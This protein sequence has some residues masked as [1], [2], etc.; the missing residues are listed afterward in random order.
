MTGTNAMAGGWHGVSGGFAQLWRLAALAWLGALPAASAA[1]EVGANVNENLDYLERALLDRSRTSWVRGFIPVLAFIDGPRR[2]ETDAGIAALRQ[3]AADGR[4]VILSL[5]WNLK[6]ANRRIPAPDSAEERAWFDWVERLLR[7]FDGQLAMFVL[8]NEP[9]IDTMNE[10]MQA[11]D[12]ED[13]PFVRFTRRLLDRVAALAVADRQGAPLPLYIGAFTRLQAEA[14]QN[15]P[16]FRGLLE[17]AD[18]DSRVAGIDVHLHNRNLEEAAAALDFARRQTAKPIVV[19]EFS[20]VWRYKAALKQPIGES[21]QGLDPRT[22]V[23][24]YLNACAAEPVGEDVWAAFLGSQPWYMKGYLSAIAQT[25]E[26]RGVSVATFA[27]SQGTEQSAEARRGRQFTA[28]KPPY[29][30]NPLFVRT[31]CRPPAP[32]TAPVSRWVFEDYLRLQSARE[33]GAEAAGR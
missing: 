31:V 33:A 15:S 21:A 24:G 27:F 16:A 28:D 2:L 3:A 20:L 14:M 32:G 9:M 12:G 26:Q 29:I 30:F 13:A 8:A 10:D 18:G 4:Q 23:L 5:K 25:M 19:T 7:D 11:A 1:L 22:S 6:I 17:L